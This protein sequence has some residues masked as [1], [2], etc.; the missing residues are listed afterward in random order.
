MLVWFSL[1]L[2]FTTMR[3][4]L[5]F[6]C[7]AMRFLFSSPSM[8]VSSAFSGFK[9]FGIMDSV[10]FVA[11][12]I[13]KMMHL[14]PE[15]FHLHL[16]LF[17]LHPKWFHMHPKMMHLHPKWYHLLTKLYLMHLKL[18]HVHLYMFLHEA[19]ENPGAARCGVE[20]VGSC[21]SQI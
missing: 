9:G 17:H 5:R 2:I 1:A 7:S 3:R 4:L 20:V 18:L 12:L 15:W 11:V 13:F 21:V 16:K 8:L 6:A 19:K 14:H 10:W